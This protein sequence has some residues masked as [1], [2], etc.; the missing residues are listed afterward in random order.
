MRRLFG[1]LVLASALQTGFALACLNTELNIGAVKEADIVLVGSIVGRHVFNGPEANH[2]VA[3]LDVETTEAI[4]NARAKHSF[5]VAGRIDG[6]EPGTGNLFIA[7]RP[8]ETSIIGQAL[9][10]TEI[11]F[12]NSEGVGVT[13]AILSVGCHEPF[14]FSANSKQAK[15]ARSILRFQRVRKIALVIAVLG[16]A[17]FVALR[18][19]AAR[20]DKSLT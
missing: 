4:R 16:V 18:F 20:S 13:H 6:M 9:K 11:G 5:L 12:T 3:I 15:E 19:N 2:T 10:P 7:A 14:V 8:I 1:Y 17:S